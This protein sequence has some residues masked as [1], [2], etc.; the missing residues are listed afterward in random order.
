MALFSLIRSRYALANLPEKRPD[1][2]SGENPERDGSESWAVAGG[3]I[4]SGSTDTTGVQ[5][6]T[7]FRAGVIPS[8][9]IKMPMEEASTAT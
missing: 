5:R 7:L 1:H 8:A 9:C 6:E 4:R 2:H 3:E